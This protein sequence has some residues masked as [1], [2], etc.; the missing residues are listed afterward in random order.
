MCYS[1]SYQI[2]ITAGFENTIQLYEI[3]PY[4]HDATKKGKLIGHVS[5]V[6]AINVIENTPMVMSA[7]DWGTIKIWDIR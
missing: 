5:M 7:D 4:F 6:C 2:L 3:N 1:T